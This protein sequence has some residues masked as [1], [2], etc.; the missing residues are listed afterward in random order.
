V[1]RAVLI[2]LVLALAAAPRLGA[3]AQAGVSVDVPA[4][5]TKTIRLRSLPQGTR[6]AVRIV[7][8]GKLLVALVGGRQLKTTEG[9]PRSVFRGVVDTRLTFKVVIPESDDYYLVLNNRRGSEPLS[10]EADIRAERAPRKPAAPKDY[11]PRPE[12]ASWSPR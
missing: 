4:R 10:V 11:S 1:P 2:A 6:I 9:R 3:G 5:E 8:T 7:S 12:K